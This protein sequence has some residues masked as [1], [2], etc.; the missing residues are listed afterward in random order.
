MQA[1]RGGQ[2]ADT[3]N[4]HQVP[5]LR[6]FLGFIGLTDVRFVFA[7]G[8]NMAEHKAQALQRALAEVAELAL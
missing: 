3:G 4:D 5:Y 8:M 2:Y 7:E 6:R 1:A